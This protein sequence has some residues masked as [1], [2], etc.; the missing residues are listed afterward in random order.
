M[1][2]FKCHIALQYNKT[3]INSLKNRQN[4][5]LN[6]H[7]HVIYLDTRRKDEYV[8]SCYTTCSHTCLLYNQCYVPN[9]KDMTIIWDKNHAF[10]GKILPVQENWILLPY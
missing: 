1:S 5:N 10:T 8:T 4:E 7:V 6:M 2:D 3:I 9:D